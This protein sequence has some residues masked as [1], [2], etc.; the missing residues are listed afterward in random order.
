MFAVDNSSTI[1]LLEY[2]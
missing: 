2:G 1:N